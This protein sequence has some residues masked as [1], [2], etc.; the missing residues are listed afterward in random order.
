MT[1]SEISFSGVRASLPVRSLAPVCRPA[2]YQRSGRVRQDFSLRQCLVREALANGSAHKA[3]EPIQRVSLAVAVVQSERELVNVPA[4]V[5]SAGVVV[6]TDNAALHDSKHALNAIGGHVAAHELAAA[7]VDRLMAKEQAADAFVGR[8]L[9]GM[10]RRADRN[11]RMDRAVHSVHIDIANRLGYG[12]AAT[13]THAEHG[14]LTDCAAPGLEF[15]S[16][17]FVR[18]LSAEIGF[19][20]FN[21]A[22]KLREVIAARFA[23]TMQDEPCA[24]L[25][26]ADLFAELNR[27]DALARRDE[28]V[29]RI[30][31]LV[32][33]DVRPLKDGAGADGEILR[34]G[35]T[36]VIAVLADADALTARADWTFN[37]IRPEARLQVEARRFLIG[38]QL[39]KLE[40]ADGD[41][42]VHD[43]CSALRSLRLLRFPCVARPSRYMYRSSRKGTGHQGVARD[44]RV[45]SDCSVSSLFDANRNDRH[46]GRKCQRISPWSMTRSTSHAPSCHAASRTD[47]STACL[48]ALTVNSSSGGGV[49]AINP[50][51]ACPLSDA[52]GAAHVYT[53][54]TIAAPSSQDTETVETW[55]PQDAVV[56]L[57][58]ALSF[59]SRFL[60]MEAIHA[61]I[62]GLDLRP[63]GRFTARIDDLGLQ[64][65]DA[66]H[67]GINER[68][69]TLCVLLKRVGVGLSGPNFATLGDLAGGDV[70]YDGGHFCSPAPESRGAAGSSI[71]CT[72]YPPNPSGSQLP[73]STSRRT[74]GSHVYKSLF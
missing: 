32:Q 22:L 2:P 53:T 65:R 67:V 21:D 29:H 58:R 48:D 7:V 30:E 24:F 23:Q 31:P 6:D 71:P 54:D 15:F 5:L 49:M 37:A 34:A 46:V 59:V 14:S 64:Y 38:E 17:V 70:G 1:P 16:F 42:V 9:V 47:I 18:L 11:L 63:V 36:T 62:S 25:C 12:F 45:P 55:L 10:Q 33:R 39:E 57:M 56:E 61:E 73:N 44:D 66:A 28:Q 4:K 52:Y 40:R 19:V 13:L 41:I 43:F 74:V 8:R 50:T 60:G 27:A 69:A 26:D 35:V 72:Q 68:P 51:P 3:I 20:D